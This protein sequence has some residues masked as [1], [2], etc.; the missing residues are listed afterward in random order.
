VT[1]IESEAAAVADALV[2]LADRDAVVVQ[3][4]VGAWRPAAGDR[5]VDAV[6]ADPARSGLGRP[7]VAAL[8][9]SGAGRLVLVSCD[10]ASLARDARL[11]V[12]L[13]WRCEEVVVVDTF[14]DTFH[15]EAVTGF[16]REESG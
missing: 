16:F 15:I 5:P 14:P 2:N 12:D 3:G 8:D 4:E 9:A 6:V 13:G 10:P 1:A 11:L 7:G